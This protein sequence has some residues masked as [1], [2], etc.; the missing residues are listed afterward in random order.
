MTKQTSSLN[1][2]REI[3]LPSKISLNYEMVEISR[4]SRLRVSGDTWGGTTWHDQGLPHGTMGEGH[5]A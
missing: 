5:M 4:F 2:S 3:L 1:L